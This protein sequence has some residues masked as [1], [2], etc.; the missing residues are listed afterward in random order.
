MEVYLGSAGKTKQIK[1]HP[2]WLDTRSQPCPALPLTAVPPRLGQRA[3]SSG[4]RKR[5]SDRRS[6]SEP[7]MSSA[8]TERARRFQAGPGRECRDLAG[9]GAPLRT[10]GPRCR[11]WPRPGQ[12]GGPALSPPSDQIPGALRDLDPLPRR[13]LPGHL[14]RAGA[15]DSCRAVIDVAANHRAAYVHPQHE[16]CAPRVRRALLRDRRLF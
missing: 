8:R 15:A 3:E 7:L 9:P 2:L 1:K 13:P 11:R 10:E 6:Q 12:I 16:A 5:V 4:E 14:L